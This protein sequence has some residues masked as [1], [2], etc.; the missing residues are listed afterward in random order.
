[1]KIILKIGTSSLTYKDG[2][3]NKE[4]IFDFAQSAA[5][6]KALGHQIIIIT[7]G[8]IGAGMGRIK[9]AKPATLRQKQALAAIG[10]P[11][12][13][14]A[15][16]EGFQK[17]GIISAQVLLTRDNFDNRGQYINIR[18]TLTELLR[19]GIIPII[20]ENDAVAVEEINFGDN[21]TLA[22]LVC[23]SI[24]AEILIVFTDV[25]GFYIGAPLKSKLLQKVEDITAEIENAA[26]EASSSKKGRGGMKTKIVAAK[27]A[28]S[29]GADFII[30]HNSKHKFLK[31][32]VEK[33]DIGTHFCAKKAGLPTK[34]LWIVFGKKARGRIFVDSIAAQMI[35]SKGK[36]LLAAGI[37][38]I[39]GKFKRGD[40]VNIADNLKN[41]FAKG[42]VNFSSDE[43]R[44][45]KGRRSKEIK[46][47]FP[48]SDEEVVH[49][50]N[51]T[52]AAE[53]EAAIH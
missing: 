49:R 15:Y 33:K 28:V 20:N 23:A 36:S 13:M 11:I 37:N 3:L 27:I 32:I 26:S 44:L 8:A 7:S 6:L 41:D 43:L 18:N 53:I 2:S 4:Y 35:A 30:A 34:K 47:I 29:C 10:Q 22:A 50:D 38:G 46:K 16:S 31:E 17:F 25:E 1:M 21:D 24:G 51:L 42:L 5:A 19:R 9:S 52:L 48:H 14:D 45:I 12:I 40:T 39:E